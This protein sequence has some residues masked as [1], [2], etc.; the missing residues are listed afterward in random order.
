LR[1]CKYFDKNETNHNAKMKGD[2]LAMFAR[3]N[4]GRKKLRSTAREERDDAKGVAGPID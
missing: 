2:N 3:G 4:K 1:R